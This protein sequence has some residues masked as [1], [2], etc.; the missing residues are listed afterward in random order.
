MQGTL[1][2][3]PVRLHK[4]SPYVIPPQV[5]CHQLSLTLALNLRSA[6]MQRVTGNTDL[7]TELTTVARY[8]FLGRSL[9]GRCIIV[10]L[11]LCQG[12]DT[13]GVD[14]AI[15]ADCPG[16]GPCA[17]TYPWTPAENRVWQ[18]MTAT[19]C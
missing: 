11:Q 2:D 1:L 9:S 13:G 6:N 18:G 15:G 19:P 16:D 10:T 4:T 17:S 12:L 14:D 7:G 5:R 8:A 3:P